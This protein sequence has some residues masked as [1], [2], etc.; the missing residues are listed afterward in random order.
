MN[1]T[2]QNE[3]LDNIKKEILRMYPITNPRKNNEHTLN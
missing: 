2:N 1:M 3:L